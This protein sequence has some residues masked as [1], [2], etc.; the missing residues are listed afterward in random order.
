MPS[1]AASSPARSSS[2]TIQL[3]DQAPPVCWARRT[4]RMSNSSCIIRRWCAGSVPTA[5][6]VAAAHLSQFHPAL[7]ALRKATTQRSCGECNASSCPTTQ[8]AEPRASG[9]GP[10]IPSGPSPSGAVA[11]ASAMVAAGSNRPALIA[12]T[13][14]TRSAMPRRTV[15]K[16]CS[17]GRRSHSRQ[18]GVT[19][20]CSTAAASA[21]SRCS[22]LDSAASRAWSCCWAAASAPASSAAAFF[23]LRRHSRRSRAAPA[24]AVTGLRIAKARNWLLCI[25]IAR[26]TPSAAGASAVNQCSRGRVVA[27]GSAGNST[28]SPSPD[29]AIRGGRCISSPPSESAVT[30]AGGSAGVTTCNSDLP[31]RTT[32]S[33]FTG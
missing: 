18:S 21:K 7:S 19:A 31:T 24:S 5:L 10:A 8:R 27:I 32:A 17:P 22:L 13:E 23:R 33:C 29:V 12:L 20:V 3:P 6:T 15:R 1:S 2:T 14:A 11:G 9:S 25:P 4:A 28:G 26:P 30:A 16:H